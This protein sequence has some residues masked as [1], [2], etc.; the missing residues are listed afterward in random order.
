MRQTTALVVF[1]A[2]TLASHASHAAQ[3]SIHASG[4]VTSI[5]PQYF[6]GYSLLGVSPGVEANVVLVVQTTTPDSAP[7]DPT[8]GVYNGAITAFS[9]ASGS[10][11]ASTSHGSCCT[12]AVQVINQNQPNSPDEWILN[13]LSMSAPDSPTIVGS[14]AQVGM[15]LIDSP[16]TSIV[17]DSVLPPSG[18]P[19]TDASM[20]LWTPA[21]GGPALSLHFDTVTVPEPATFG[22]V[23]AVALI[24]FARRGHFWGSQSGRV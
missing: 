16:G 17:T 18:A 11:S 24:A 7:L 8:R 15:Y 4:T 10:W 5:D 2:L 23:A 22:L 9:I 12:G 19:W 21:L 6:Y 1:V 14:V 20:D 3:I 13:Y